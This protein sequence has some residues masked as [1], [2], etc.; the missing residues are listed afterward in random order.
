[1]GC[2]KSTA[3]QEVYSYKHIKEEKSQINS[4]TLQLKELKKEQIKTKANKRKEITKIKQI[5]RIEKHQRKLNQ[6]FFL[7]KST[8][9][10]N[11][12]LMWTKK[13][14]TEIT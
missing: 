11:I 13:K 6:E 4:L 10:T 9:L 5:Y 3:K 2:G 8:K 12:Q 1:M 14:K 7:K